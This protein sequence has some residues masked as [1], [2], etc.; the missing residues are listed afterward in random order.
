MKSRVTHMRSGHEPSKCL[1]IYVFLWCPGCDRKHVF[2]FR[3]PEHGGPE[4][5][6]WEGDPYS[7][8]PDFPPTPSSSNSLR[9]SWVTDDGVTVQCH[10][11]VKAG[12]W[13]FLGDCTAHALR[14]FYDLPDLPDW[15]GE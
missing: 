9:T 10:S 14:G 7:D 2:V 15:L 4:G 12:Q 8:P 13:E 11:Y 6:V 3:C 1:G 5:V